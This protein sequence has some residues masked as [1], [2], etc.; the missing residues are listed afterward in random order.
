MWSECDERAFFLP[1]TT[2]LVPAEELSGNLDPLGTLTYAEHLAEA[3]LPGFTVRMWRGEAVSELLPW[4]SA[5]EGKFKQMVAVA[6]FFPM[7]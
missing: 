5:D 7:Y 1:F 4:L 2:D 6:I 3:L